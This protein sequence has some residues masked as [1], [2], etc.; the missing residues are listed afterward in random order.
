MGSIFLCLSHPFQQA[1]FWI[2]A[3][4]KTILCS[5]IWIRLRVPLM[6]AALSKLQMSPL[7]NHCN[8]HIIHAAVW[9]ANVSPD[10]CHICPHLPTSSAYLFISSPF[11]WEIFWYMFYILRLPRGSDSYI[12]FVSPAL[13]PH[14]PPLFGDHMN[15]Y[16]FEKDSFQSKVVLPAAPPH[17]CSVTS[18]IHRKFNKGFLNLWIWFINNDVY[19]DK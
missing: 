6:P 17:P 7:C 4:Y 11:K 16:S 15:C 14:H 5:N 9:T 10:W 2:H 18:P 3:T 12:I 13:S 19:L 8:V 1:C